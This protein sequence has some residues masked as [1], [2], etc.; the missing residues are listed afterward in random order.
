MQGFLGFELGTDGSGHQYL[1]IPAG[2][3]RR[4]LSTDTAVESVDEQ[5]NSRTPENLYM[6][7]VAIF[8]FAITV[9][10]EAVRSLLTKLSLTMA[11]IDLFLFHQANKYMLEYLLKKMKIPVEK[12]HFFIEEIGNTSGS[13]IPI[14]LTD[15]WRAGKV[16]SGALV[17]AIGFGVGLSWAATVIR[18]PDKTL[19]PVSA[20]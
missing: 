20:G 17:L 12:T 5:G 3:F 2:G 15:A 18:W 1:M 6:N 10:P 4:P 19:G 7:G 9:V 11:D 14:L 16:R 8:H 13:T